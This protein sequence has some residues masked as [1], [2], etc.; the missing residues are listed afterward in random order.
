MYWYLKVIK[1]F[2]DFS[3]RASRKE[4]W[5]FILINILI[6]GALLLISFK[7]D[8]VIFLAIL[9]TLAMAIPYTAVSVRR[10]HDINKSGWMILV[11]I[12]PLIGA[13]WF[14]ILTVTESTHGSN[15][16]GPDPKDSIIR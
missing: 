12:I 6:S 2:M 3:G 5:M 15:Q 11:E 16:Y 9:Y 7:V 13:I 4:Y 8:V 1:Q 14:L 10:M